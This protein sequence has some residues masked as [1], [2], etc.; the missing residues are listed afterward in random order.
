MCLIIRFFW[1]I[2]THVS[3]VSFWGTDGF[4]CADF[5]DQLG[6]LGGHD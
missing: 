1:E 5:D 3:V 2:V 4:G 6:P